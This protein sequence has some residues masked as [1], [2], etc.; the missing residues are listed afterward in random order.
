MLVHPIRSTDYRLIP[1]GEPQ[2][3]HKVAVLLNA[4]ARKVTRKVVRSL[5][6]VVPQEDLFV[7]ESLQDARRIA[8]LVVDRR[9]AT[10]FTGGGDGTFVGFMNEIYRQLEIRSRYFPQAAPR[11][12]VLKLGTGNGLSSLVNASSLRGD[13][14]LDDVVRARAGEVPGYRRLDL[15]QIEGKR[16]PFAGLGVDGKLLNDYI[17]V[18]ENLGKGALKGMLTGPGGYLTSVALRTLPHYVTNST[19]VEA[20]VFNTSRVPV[21]RLNP[22][23]TVMGEVAPG[24]L[25]YRGRIMMCAAATI[26]FY[27]FNFRMFPF[28][29]RTP[30]HMHLR[31][32]AVTA[33]E[34]VVNLTKLWKGRWFNDRIFDFQADD[35]T[36]KFARPMPFQIGG[37]AEG[38]R[39]ELR[40]QVAEE[41]VQLVDFTGAVH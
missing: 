4:N 17:W 22:D 15:L 34:T 35:V 2:T 32:A 18:K 27:G 29:G 11:F 38:Y 28:A 5:S 30:G 8:Q 13:G 21:Q 40:I 12:G 26:P 20:E 6:H 23:G 24:E 19:L 37:D 16:T 25:M 33:A 9:Y 36:I 14:F 7:S 41:P 1:R 31:L 39:S 10:V 3:E